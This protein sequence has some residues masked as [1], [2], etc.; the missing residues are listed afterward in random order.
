MDFANLNI[1]EIR[2]DS[3]DDKQYTLGS[4]KADVS[5][6]VFGST[7]SSGTAAAVKTATTELE[8][9]GVRSGRVYL[10]EINKGGLETARPYVQ[11]NPSYVHVAS[12]PEGAGGG[13]YYNNIF[14]DISK[15]CDGE[16]F[17]T[18]KTSMPAVCVLDGACKPVYLASQKTFDQAKLHS[19]LAP[20]AGKPF[21]DVPQW[22]SP[23]VN[24]AVAGQITTGTSTTAF[25]PDDDCTHGH[26]LTFLW[27]A[28]GEPTSS[29][30]APVPLKGDEWYA[31]A[32]RWA[33]GK[34]LID[35]DFLVDAPCTRASA[36]S[37]I[38]Q[39]FGSP[40]AARSSFPDVSPDSSYAAAVDWA[41]A[42][43]ITNGTSGGNFSPGDVCSRGQIVTFLRRAYVEEARLATAS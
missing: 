14:W 41:L 15:A 30:Q 40:E 24:W 12:T 5:V 28:A 8:A 21:T 26:I 7:A 25:S 39:A 31:G 29:A 11:E 16:N 32:V 9:L 22:C 18:Q 35:A 20:F 33:A 10:L 17:D 34:G 3:T 6:L 1:A 27:R 42:N 23:A 38:W 4:V 13:G 37:Y 2:A 43:G 36:V 19:A